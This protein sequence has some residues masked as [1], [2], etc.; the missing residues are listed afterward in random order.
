MLYYNRLLHRETYIDEDVSTS[1]QSRYTFLYYCLLLIAYL[2]TKTPF[3][4]K[5][6]DAL[7][8]NVC[9]E[10]LREDNPGHTDGIT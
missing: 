2:K 3:S 10:R 9:C 5:S 6:Q 8:N 4:V 7:K 1:K